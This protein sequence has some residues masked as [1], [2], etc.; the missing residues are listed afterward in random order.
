ME[1]ITVEFKNKFSNG[2]VLAGGKWMQVAKSVEL[3]NFRKDSQVS[4]ELRTNNKGYTSIVGLGTLDSRTPQAETVAEKPKRKK[5][6]TTEV[7][8]APK[9]NTNYET[10]KNTRIQIQGLLQ[11]TI[12]SPVTINFGDDPKVVAEKVLELTDLLIDGMNS[13]I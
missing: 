5:Q 1:T 4:V 10:D 9:V 6:E 7:D 2:S 11:A 3:S 13:R 12:Q 8:T